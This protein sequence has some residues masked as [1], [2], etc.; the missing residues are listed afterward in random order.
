MS[1]ITR[2]ACNNG[3]LTRINQAIAPR[4]EGRIRIVS[5]A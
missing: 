5:G 2:V 1:L 3:L 4:L